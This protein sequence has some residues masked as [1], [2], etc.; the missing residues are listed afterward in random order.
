ML[1]LKGSRGFSI[2]CILLLC[3]VLASFILLPSPALAQV[4][5]AKISAF[6]IT[7]QDGREVMGQ[8]LIAGVVYDI[9]F[10]IE[11]AAG[12]KDKAILGTDLEREGDRYWTLEGDYPGIDLSSWQPG[13][14]SI[15]FEMAEGTAHFVLTGYISKEYTTTTLE[16]GEI[17]H[18][19]ESLVVLALSLESGGSLEERSFEVIDDVLET[20]RD[21]LD[22]KVEL[23]KEME[24]DAAYVDLVEAVLETAQTEADEGYTERALALLGIIP[25]TGWATP[26]G[27][28]MVLIVVIAVLAV[29]A[30]L[31]L[32]LLFRSKSEA[33]LLKRRADEEAKKLDIVSARVMKIGEKSLAGEIS[34]VKDALE[35][36]SGR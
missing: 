12:V 28:N 26:Q 24:A 11:V 30:L 10:T 27:S 21:T 15:S 31:V 23:T 3:S 8:P 20:Y 32:I 1:E 5:P 33:G 9:S 7:T 13:Q 19:G 25:E 34:Q 22:V 6:K 36:M 4:V 16:N 35:S 2:I 18:H 29:I 14:Q 17:L